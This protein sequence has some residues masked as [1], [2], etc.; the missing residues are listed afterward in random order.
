VLLE[1]KVTI[2][3]NFESNLPI[4]RY[5]F[6]EALVSVKLIFLL[7]GTILFVMPISAATYK[8]RGQWLSTI[9]GEN[10]S[11]VQTLTNSFTILLGTN[12]YRI[13]SFD[14]D[15][16]LPC[17][18][19]FDGSEVSSIRRGFIIQDGQEIPRLTDPTFSGSR[20]PR[21]YIDKTIEIG[22]LE[23]GDRPDHSSKILRFLW[24]IY[25]VGKPGMT[26]SDL[27]VRSMPVAN[28]EAHLGI[29]NHS[30]VA[31]RNQN[32]AFLES[33]DL[34]CSPEVIEG[35]GRGGKL[36]A[37]FDTGF[38]CLRL[39]TSQWTNYDGISFPKVSEIETLVADYRSTP[40]PKSLRDTQVHRR[41]VFKCF[42]VERLEVSIDPLPL[43]RAKTWLD[44][45]RL[46][47]KYN[48]STWITNGSWP[49]L[50]IN[51]LPSDF[52]RI[53]QREIDRLEQLEQL[54]RLSN[55]L[56]PEQAPVSR[57][58]IVICFFVS[59]VLAPFVIV[60]KFIKN[61]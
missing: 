28:Q 11:P 45:Y 47:G 37:P 24:L 59:M 17:E 21:I 34:F 35:R 26:D 60:L 22:T 14:L 53:R 4:P 5:R 38:L 44:D 10:S 54:K 7:I 48:T 1:F 30:R 52:D 20:D 9:L 61:K 29:T 3:N 58:I 23:L 15:S 56:M 43:E 12:S 25:A 16:G 39:R 46:L 27:L 31:L 19:R 55:R 33:A 49:S 50:D 6:S 18:T 40:K 2:V 42:S 13:D 8:I 32:D 51:A 41:L 36:V 57:W